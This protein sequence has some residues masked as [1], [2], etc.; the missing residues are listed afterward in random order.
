MLHL[1]VFLLACHNGAPVESASPPGEAPALMGARPAAPIAAPE[2]AAVSHDGS[3]RS[4]ADLVGH[5][6]VV[7]FFPAAGTPG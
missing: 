7:W 3:P 1:L 6:T 2:F 5:P 4:K